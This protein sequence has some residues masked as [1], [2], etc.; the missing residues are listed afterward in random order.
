MKVTL[1]REN[2]E[3]EQHLSTRKQD[4]SGVGINYLD[5][6]MA[7][8]KATAADGRRITFKRRG[9]KLTFLIGERNGEGLLRRLRD[10]PD[11]KNIV[12]RALEEAARNVGARFDI[13]NGMLILELDQAAG[14]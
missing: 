3:A 6:Y 14:E 12:R 2:P 7:G 5:A 8:M 11:E 9:L 1:G 10:G 4:G 13:E